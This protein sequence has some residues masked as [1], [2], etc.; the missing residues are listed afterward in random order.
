MPIEKTPLVLTIGSFDGLH[1]GHQTIIHRVKE[2]A[3]ELQGTSGMVTFHPL[4]AQLLHP[5][6]PYLLTTIDEKIPLL[7][8]LGIQFTYIIEFNQQLRTTEPEQFIEEHIIKPL[9]PTV[10][11]LGADHRFGKNGRGDINLLR[12]ILKPHDV[13]LETVPE[14]HHLGAPVKSTRIREHLVLGHIRLAVELLGRPYAFTGKVTSG[15]G[16]GRRLGFP[17]I[18]L[19]PEHREKLLPAEGVYA[20]IAETPLGNF[21]GVLNIGFRPTFGGSNRTIETHLLDYPANAPKVE[22]V[23]IHFLERIRPEIRFDTPAQ[24][25]RQIEQD[26][27]I[28]RQ[29]IEDSIYRDYFLR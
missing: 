23:T 14:F 7:T 25:K 11:V 10:L 24:L 8:E 17:T 1:L 3:R 21:G 5:D 18:N 2:I 27:T 26:V 4:P 28:A 22:K 6:F 19:V 29:L 16:T 9:R 20:V 13:Q 12:T 15:S